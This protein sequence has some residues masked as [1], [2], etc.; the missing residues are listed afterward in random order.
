MNLD[1]GGIKIFLMTLGAGCLYA[2][3]NISQAHFSSVTEDRVMLGL[4]ATVAAIGILVGKPLLQAGLS[5]LET[6]GVIKK[7]QSKV[8]TREVDAPAQGSQE[9]GLSK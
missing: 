6:T 1:T 9:T 5:A 8:D 3:T 4:G 7:D 2:M